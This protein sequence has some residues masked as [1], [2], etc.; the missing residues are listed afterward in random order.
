MEKKDTFSYSSHSKTIEVLFFTVTFFLWGN[1]GVHAGMDGSAHFKIPYQ[2]EPI[3]ENYLIESNGAELYLE[4]KGKDRTKPILLFLHGGP[5]DVVFGLLPFQVYAGK[6]LE[7]NF[8]MAYFH[9]RGM[10]KSKPVPN[11][12]QTIENHINDVATVVDFLV[13]KMNREKVMLMGHSWGGLLGTLYLL[14]DQSKIDRFIAI[15]SPFNFKENSTE[16]YLYTMKWAREQKN[17]QAIKE[18]EALAKPV[19]DTFDKMLVRSK[20]ASQAYEGIAKNIS[21]QKV[22]GES[23]IKELKQEWQLMAMEVA[24]VMFD[25][26]DKVEIGEAINSI[27][28]PI[29]FMAGRND[30]TVPPIT[31]ENAFTLYESEKKYVLFEESHHLLFV[32]EPEL[33]VDEIKRFGS[34]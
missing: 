11:S 26:L 31:V 28:V 5:G 27:K 16:S 14:Q 18:L 13:E 24:K 1:I 19:A 10:V 4:I 8:V 34:K 7:N 25:S 6:E 3:D 22:L 23:G 20:W 9:Q 32:D 21:I 15:A 2:Q 17:E 12:S 33:F 29:L 30:A